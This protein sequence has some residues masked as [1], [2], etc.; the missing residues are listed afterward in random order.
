MKKGRKE[1]NEAE[2]NRM[3]GKRKGRKKE[4]KKLQ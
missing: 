4:D 1:K 2:E 3:K